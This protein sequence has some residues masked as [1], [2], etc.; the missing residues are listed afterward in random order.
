[1]ST[2]PS[3]AYYYSTLTMSKQTDNHGLRSSM[4]SKNPKRWKDGLESGTSQ[5]NFWPSGYDK[6]MG[7]A[8]SIRQHRDSQPIGPAKE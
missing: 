1:M 2:T 8:G 5:D 6:G 4:R 7:K 3:I